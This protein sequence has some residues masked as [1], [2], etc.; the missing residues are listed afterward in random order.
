MFYYMR[1]KQNKSILCRFSFNLLKPLSP[2]CVFSYKVRVMRVNF[3]WRRFGHALNIFITYKHLCDTECQQ[4]DTGATPK[5]NRKRRVTC[6]EKLKRRTKNSIENDRPMCWGNYSK[7]FY[8]EMSFNFRI[9]WSNIK[10]DNVD[11]KRFRLGC[12]LLM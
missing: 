9:N 11:R 10:V 1:E 6:S 8:N 5:S 7:L 3:L 12:F 4:P 2:A